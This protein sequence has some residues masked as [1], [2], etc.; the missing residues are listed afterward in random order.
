MLKTCSVCGRIHDFN[1]V[2]K[3]RKKQKPTEATKFRKTNQWTEKS[4]SIRARDKHLCQVCITGKYNT[5]YR[6]TYRELEVHHIVPIE[7]DYSKRLDSDNLITLCRYHHE[8]AEKGQI[9]R[10][11]LQE[12]VAGNNNIPPTISK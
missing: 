3:R 7:E 4:K 5:N 12:I 1:K 8:M 10:E 6:Y 2:C 9:S 11:E